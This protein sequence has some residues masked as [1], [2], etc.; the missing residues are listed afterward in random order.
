[1]L[2]PPCLQAILLLDADFVATPTMLAPYKTPQVLRY[3]PT[4]QDWCGIPLLRMKAILSVTLGCRLAY[5]A[6]ERLQDQHCHCEPAQ[7]SEC[8][9]G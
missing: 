2:L 1:M 7:A 3:L 6:T 5:D 9:P 8:L 4:G